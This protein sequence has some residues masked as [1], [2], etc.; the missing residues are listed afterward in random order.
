[1]DFRTRLEFCYRKQVTSIILQY[2]NPVMANWR[3][4]KPT[5]VCL[6]RQKL[7]RVRAEAGYVTYENILLFN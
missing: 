5:L 4:F 6:S 2:T 3:L 7:S 1:M